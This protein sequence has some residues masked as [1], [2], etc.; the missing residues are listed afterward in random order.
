MKIRQVT[1]R[2]M[3][4][5]RGRPTGEVEVV[6]EDGTSGLGIAPA[7]ASRGTQEAVEL[8]DGGERFHGLD[9]RKAIAGI[10]REIAPALV[11]RDTT[12]QASIDAML[13]ALD[14]TPN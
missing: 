9:V 4:D 2:R 14:G 1:A 8:R 11:G 12:E 6:C 10:E 13:T 7:G 5:S 3:W